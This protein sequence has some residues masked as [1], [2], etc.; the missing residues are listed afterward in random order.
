MTAVCVAVVLCEGI[1]SLP[2]SVL[3]HELYF[4]RNQ[5][6]LLKMLNTAHYLPVEVYLHCPA[7]VTW[8]SPLHSWLC[9]PQA[10]ISMAWQQ[11]TCV[12]F[13]WRDWSQLLTKPLTRLITVTDKATSESKRWTLA[14]IER[15]F[16]LTILEQRCRQCYY[17]TCEVYETSLKDWLFQSNAFYKSLIYLL[18]WYS[19]FQ[20]Y[21]IYSYDAPKSSSQKVKLVT[22]GVYTSFVVFTH[23]D[24]V[25]GKLKSL[26]IMPLKP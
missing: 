5:V 24:L 4:S 9:R 15:A 26:E 22:A 12:V 14:D 19:Y 6:H 13:H 23:V 8:D 21:V 11:L 17:A 25:N 1:I 16:R 3:S 10:C 2:H 7:S 18:A 20:K